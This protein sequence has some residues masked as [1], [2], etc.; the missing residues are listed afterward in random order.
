MAVKFFYPYFGLRVY[1]EFDYGHGVAIGETGN[2]LECIYFHLS[3]NFD[4]LLEYDFY[5]FLN[6]YSFAIGPILGIR[7]GYLIY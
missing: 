1:G 3:A 4:L 2:T 7:Y 6:G 5:K